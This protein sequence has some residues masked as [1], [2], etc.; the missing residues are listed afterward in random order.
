MLGVLVT[1]TSCSAAL[2]ELLESTEPA[3]IFEQI[4]LVA[5][6]KMRGVDWAIIT[7]SFHASLNLFLNI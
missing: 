5:V 1:G 7:V 3:L 2:Q 6:G 4:P